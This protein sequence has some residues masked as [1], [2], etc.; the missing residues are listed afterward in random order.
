MIRYEHTQRG[1]VVQVA[2]LLGA[3]VCFGL[4]QFFPAPPFVVPMVLA[5][6]VIC[7]YM[8]SS[9]T[10]Q[11]TNR[12]VHWCFGPGMFRKE[13]AFTD[14]KGVEVTR[15]RFL[16]GWGIHKTARGW[17]Y[18]V[19]G[20]DAILISLHGGKVILLG[21][22]EPEVLRAAIVKAIGRGR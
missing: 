21:T 11:V 15:T 19:S 6:F 7:A 10:I 16:E 4:S 2:F 3:V 12:A 22:D 8:F 9:L 5:V 1:T 14:I 13:L 17:L 20:F 18:N